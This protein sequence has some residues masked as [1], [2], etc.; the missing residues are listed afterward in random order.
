MK[1]T[2]ITGLST[3]ALL[4]AFA[5]LANAGLEKAV[6]RQVAYLDQ[7]IEVLNQAKACFKKATDSSDIRSCHKHRQKSL[8]KLR[9]S[10]AKK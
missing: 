6:D 5:S 8:K 10:R 4:S 3:I 1:K 7:E 2:I 9:E